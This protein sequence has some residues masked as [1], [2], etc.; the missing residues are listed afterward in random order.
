MAKKEETPMPT[1][2]EL[3]KAL[4]VLEN[5]LSKT[6]KE[7]Q[8]VLGELEAVER[9]EKEELHQKLL[10]HMEGL[11][12]AAKHTCAVPALYGDEYSRCPKCILIACQRTKYIN[13]DLHIRV[14]ID[15]DEY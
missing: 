13:M 14:E 7:K 11:I 15:R 4:A 1:K 9:R 12:L 10:P 8:R 5:E 3:M 6:A 2:A